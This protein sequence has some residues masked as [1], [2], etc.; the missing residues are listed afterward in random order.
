MKKKDLVDRLLQCFAEVKH[1]RG[2]GMIAKDVEQL[3]IEKA[4]GLSALGMATCVR[5]L[6]EFETALIEH[7][8]LRQSYSETV[9]QRFKH[10][11]CDEWDVRKA[12]ETRIY[13]LWQARPSI[14]K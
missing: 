3:T 7:R 4:T 11:E 8:K 1:C 9:W 2:G 6:K 14:L 12:K 10:L 13:K 5:W